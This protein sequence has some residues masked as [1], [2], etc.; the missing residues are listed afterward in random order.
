LIF[1]FS[2][3]GFMRPLPPVREVMVLMLG[4]AACSFSPDIGASC[5][6]FV[7][8]PFLCSSMDLPRSRCKT[9]RSKRAGDCSGLS[10]LFHSYASPQRPRS[11][12]DSPFS[13]FLGVTPSVLHPDR[14]RDRPGSSRSPPPRAFLSPVLIFPLLSF[15]QTGWWLGEDGLAAGMSAPAF[16]VDRGALADM[17]ILCDIFPFRFSFVSSELFQSVSVP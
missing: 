6:V 15:P 5:A 2:P 3:L 13:S 1:V 8:W 11:P 17:F 16:Y 7:N 9:W 14:P 10:F 12:F 4:Y